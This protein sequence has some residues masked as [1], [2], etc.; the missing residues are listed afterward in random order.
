M[1]KTDHTIN[2]DI[3]KESHI[4]PVEPFLENRSVLTTARGENTTT[5]MCKIAEDKF[6]RDAAEVDRKRHRGIT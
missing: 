3:R 6:L 1:G 2:N 4:K 5:Y